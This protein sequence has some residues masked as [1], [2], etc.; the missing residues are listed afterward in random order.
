MRPTLLGTANLL[1]ALGISGLAL[2]AS[3]Q[4]DALGTAWPGNRVPVVS[5][6]VVGSY[7]VA[8]SYSE[9]VSLGSGSLTAISVPDRSPDP[10]KLPEAYREIESVRIPSI[11]LASQVVPALLAEH[12]QGVAWEVPRFKVGHGDGTAGAGQEGNSVL[13][14]HITSQGLGNVFLHLDRVHPGDLV[15]VGSGEQEFA[16]LVDDVRLVGRTDLSVI[17]PT[18]T[19]SITLIT[20]AGAWLPKEQDYAQRLVVT[21][22]LT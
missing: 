17:Q 5:Y 16:Y 6:P 22:Q 3:D 2:T 14:G 10:V 1:I 8:V 11:A 13:F 4:G 19:A 7:P 21:G 12:P 20:C 18:T 15:Y 9:S